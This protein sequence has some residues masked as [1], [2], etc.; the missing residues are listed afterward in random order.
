MRGRFGGAAGKAVAR[1]TRDRRMIAV[2]E[3]R[4]SQHPARGLSERDKLPSGCSARQPRGT[5]SDHS[6]SLV[7]AE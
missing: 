2:S 4:M 1:G 3:E 6:G 5:S 7:E